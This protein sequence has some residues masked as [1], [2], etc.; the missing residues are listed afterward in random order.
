MTIK[1]YC[2]LPIKSNTSQQQV[3]LN[4]NF[5]RPMPNYINLN[6]GDNQ[7]KAYYLMGEL[8]IKWSYFSGGAFDNML[9]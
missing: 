3:L 7:I 2:Q 9:Y 1:G 5:C 8:F 4:F 6:H